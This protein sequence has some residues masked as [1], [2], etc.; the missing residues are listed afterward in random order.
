[1]LTYPDISPVAVA[2]GSFEVHWY[3]LMYL[4]AFGTGWWLGLLRTRRAGTEWRAAEI[5][6]ANGHVV[7][8]NDT[9]IRVCLRQ[10]DDDALGSACAVVD[11]P[12]RKVRAPSTA[13]VGKHGVPG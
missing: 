2:V 10:V 8:A 1:M 3:G 12:D 4:L 13:V 6:A 9:A 5:P 7:H 11:L